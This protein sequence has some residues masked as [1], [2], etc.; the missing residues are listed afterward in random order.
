MLQTRPLLET[1]NYNIVSTGINSYILS[2]DDIYSKDWYYD[3]IAKKVVQCKFATRSHYTFKDEN[4][5]KFIRENYFKIIASTENLGIYAYGIKRAL[6][7]KIKHL[8]M[9]AL[10]VEPVEMPDLITVKYVPKIESGCVII[11]I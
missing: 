10:K 6:F 1:A 9:V 11:N 4:S 2:D 7:S 3:V 5:P 8:N